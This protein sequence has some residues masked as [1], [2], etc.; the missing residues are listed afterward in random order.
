MTCP[1]LHDE[2]C[3]WCGKPLTGRQKRWCSRTCTRAHRANHRWTQAREAALVD[4]TWFQCARCEWL[5]QRSDVQVNHI[6]PI[7][8][9]HNQW[10]CWHHQDNL[11]VLCIPCHQEATNDQRKK[12][13]I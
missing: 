7:K 9:K 6:D 5:F 1:L 2:G 12:G 13:L 8:G 4:A 10:G 3:Q 11:E